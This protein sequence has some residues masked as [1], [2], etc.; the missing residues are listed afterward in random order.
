MSV[1]NGTGNTGGTGGNGGSSGGSS[2]TGSQ[3]GGAHTGGTSGAG[4]GSA[5]G[6]ASSDWLTGLSDEHKGYVANKQF[7]AP[8]DLLE[9]Y[10]QLEKLRG[11]PAERL[12]KLPDNDK[13]PAWNEIYGKLGRPGKPEEYGLK[14]EEDPE[15]AKFLSEKAHSLGLSKKQTE[16]LFG[17][18]MVY[19][20]TVIEQMQSAQETKHSEE[21]TALKREWGSAYEQNANIVD[22]A[23]AEL[24]LSEEQL[25]A[26]KG[27]LGPAGTMKLLHTIGSKTGEATFETGSGGGGFGGALAPAAAKARI[28]SLQQDSEFSNKL[29]M[30][31]TS[32]IEEWARLHKMAYP[33]SA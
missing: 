32:A 30:G 22:R 10:I 31:D 1:Q 6:A 20:K 23:A 9:S 14:G 29:T 16:T 5:T 26:L 25:T 18:L 21:A 15:F 7:K 3:T 27:A 17:E 24:E 33:E 8:V 4:G 2:G 28:Q 12:L 13:D 19:S 11:L